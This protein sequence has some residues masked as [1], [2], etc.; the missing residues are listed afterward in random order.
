MAQ[1]QP[2]TGE[3][4]TVDP[5]TGAEKGV[6]LARADLVPPGPYLE[7]ATHYGMGAEKYEARNW[8]AGYAWS[9]SYGAALRHLNQFWGGEDLDPDPFYDQF[10]PELRPKHV[11]AA[12]WHCFALAE[13]MRT[14]R[15][16]DDRPEVARRDR[17]LAKV[18]GPA[19]GHIDINGTKG[20]SRDQQRRMHE[21]VTR[22]V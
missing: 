6:K 18:I 14:H 9:K 21:A 22:G 16:K 1:D 4:R 20:Y 12:A 5:D 11:T 7:L 13:W 15:E 19:I 3:V 8:E 2:G 17:E 10:P